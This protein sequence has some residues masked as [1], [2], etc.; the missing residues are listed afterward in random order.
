MRGAG[1]V[2]LGESSCLHSRRTNR[3]GA[4][5]NH[6]QNISEKRLD[7]ILSIPPTLYEVMSPDRIEIDSRQLIFWNHAHG[8][9][10]KIKNTFMGVMSFNMNRHINI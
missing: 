4:W 7:P 6:R 8:S 1:A 2:P 3:D 10:F 9:A 5:T